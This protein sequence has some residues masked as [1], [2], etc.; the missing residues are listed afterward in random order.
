MSA[1]KKQRTNPE[2]HSGGKKN[3]KGSGKGGGKG[4]SVKTEPQVEMSSAIKADDMEWIKGN[5]PWHQCTREYSFL[6]TKNLTYRNMYQ[7]VC[8]KFSTNRLHRRKAVVPDWLS[9]V[10]GRSEGPQQAVNRKPLKPLF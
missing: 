2:E 5:K 6:C 7:S 8:S 3:T 10:I 1:N 9:T 4:A